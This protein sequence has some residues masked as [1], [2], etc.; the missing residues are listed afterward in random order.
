M[1]S[2]SGL[3]GAGRSRM[4][5]RRVSFAVPAI[6]VVVVVGLAAACSPQESA[7][8]SPG[9][10][11]SETA[12]PKPTSWPTGTIEAAIALGAANGE[13]TKMT[14]DL[15]AA[16][17]SQDPARIETAMNDALTFLAGNQQNIPKLEEY[18]GTKALGDRLAPV[19]EKM[20]AGATQVRDGLRNGDAAAVEA[21]FTAF[22]EGTTEYAALSSDVATAAE[23]ALFMKRQLL[24]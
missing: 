8:A 2:V 14:D 4:P 10:V 18:D 17:D 6:L 3:R 19:Y 24:R 15:A 13:F 7:S 12:G 1:K 20:I 5:V 16:V 23:Q 9:P 22:F 21:G 11:A